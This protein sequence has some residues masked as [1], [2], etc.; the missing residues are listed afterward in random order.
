MWR[1]DGVRAFET[2]PACPSALEQRASL[3]DRSEGVALGQKPEQVPPLDLGLGVRN[4]VAS[5]LDRHSVRTRQRRTR[6]HS[7]PWPSNLPIALGTGTGQVGGVG[8]VRWPV[9]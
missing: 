7:R 5:E 6:L 3:L 4:D 8:F 2:V 1:V 9:W